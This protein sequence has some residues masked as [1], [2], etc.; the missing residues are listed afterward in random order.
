MRIKEFILTC[1]RSPEIPQDKIGLSKKAREFI[2]VN[3]TDAI[4][5]AV[6]QIPLD[7]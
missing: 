6:Y 2:Y 4:P 5:V 3:M 1:N 7:R